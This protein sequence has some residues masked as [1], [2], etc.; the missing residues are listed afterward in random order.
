MPILLLTNRADPW[1]E[2]KM[3]RIFTDIYEPM[4]GHFKKRYKKECKLFVEAKE[5]FQK[6]S[7]HNKHDYEL[8]TIVEDFNTENLYMEMAYDYAEYCLGPGV[9]FD[10]DSFFKEFEFNNSTRIE[11]MSSWIEQNLELEI[12]C[13]ENL[14]ENI[15]EAL[16]A[17]IRLKLILHNFRYYW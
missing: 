8:G 12:Y 10:L 3:S 6:L 4:L 2:K 11:T 1:L 15:L 7:S 5:A 16:R 14:M 9:P 13:V 17:F